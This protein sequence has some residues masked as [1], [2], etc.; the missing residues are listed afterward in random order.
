MH[1]D[2]DVHGV[3]VNNVL[4]GFCVSNFLVDCELHSGCEFDA[5]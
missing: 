5:E 2:V 1:G 3:I 4:D